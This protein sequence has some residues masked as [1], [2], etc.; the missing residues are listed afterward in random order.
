MG[1]TTGAA[2]PEPATVLLVVDD[3]MLGAVLAEALEAEGFA[4]LRAQDDDSISRLA[5]EGM[6]DLVILDLR[7][8]TRPALQI[9]D[10]LRRDRVTREIPMLITSDTEMPH[11]ME[12]RAAD[13]LLPMPFDLDIFLEHVWRAINGRLERVAASSP[14]TRGNTQPG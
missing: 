10:R 3:P 12:L 11:G 6:P 2:T 4:V 1:T 7:L 14:R 5:R 13:A 8:T 9:V